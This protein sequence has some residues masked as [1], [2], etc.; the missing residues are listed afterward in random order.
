MMIHD[1]RS[2]FA[3]NDTITIQFRA[4]NFQ[5]RPNGLSRRS[6]CY[7]AQNLI[8]YLSAVERNENEVKIESFK[9]LFCLHTPAF[10]LGQELIFSL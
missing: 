10:Q 5:R 2:N 4:D 7:F 3:C 1:F 8:F 9:F 6:E